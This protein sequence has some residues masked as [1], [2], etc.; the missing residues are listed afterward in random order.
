MQEQL[1]LNTI[2]DINTSELSSIGDFNREVSKFQDK[3]NIEL[4]FNENARWRPGSYE[5]LKMKMVESLFINWSKPKGANTIKKITRFNQYNCKNFRRALIKIDDQLRVFRQEKLSLNGEEAKKNGDIILKEYFNHLL[6]PAKGITVEI[7]TIPWYTRQR[8]H[9][10]GISPNGWES[11]Y[12]MPSHPIFNSTGELETA[13][14][15]MSN[16]EYC[17]KLEAYKNVTNPNRWFV[18]I[19]YVINDININYIRNRTSQEVITSTPYGNLVACFSVPL[20]D[21]IIGYRQMKVAKNHMDGNT[22][23]NQGSISNHTHTFPKYSS[24]LH[25]FVKNPSGTNA[26]YYT[27]DMGNTCF[28]DYKVDIQNAIYSGQMNTLKHLLDFWSCTYYLGNTNPLNQGNYHHI[29][30]PKEWTEKKLGF[31]I[32]AYIGTSIDRCIELVYGRNRI[33]LNTDKKVIDTH[34]ENHC[35]NCQLANDDNCELYKVW[36]RKP[37]TLSPEIITSLEEHELYSTLPGFKSMYSTVFELKSASTRKSQFIR[38][39]MRIY[40]KGRDSIEIQITG[41]SIDYQ[42]CEIYNR[43][44]NPFDSE[45]TI[46]DFNRAMYIFYKIAERV[47]VNSILCNIDIDTYHRLNED[48]LYNSYYEAEENCSIDAIKQMINTLCIST[49]RELPNYDFDNWINNL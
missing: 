40:T 38:E 20:L 39:L 21:A 36:H 25:P 43:I 23:G 35:N 34:K 29:G 33:E 47:F 12:D 5:R 16:I 22:Y 26:I 9:N 4:E 13:N 37:I 42:C 32:G 10:Y 27:Y 44:E 41:S 31:P 3:W 30:L 14:S 2:P 15:N 49:N 28:G 24:I 48:N 45:N 1:Q 17:D 18:N 6:R 19:K 7:S 11:E 8:R 46:H